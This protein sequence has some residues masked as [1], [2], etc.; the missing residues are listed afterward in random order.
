[1][2]NRVL[3]KIVTRSDVSDALA[4]QSEMLR[5]LSKLDSISL[6]Q[7][8]ELMEEVGKLC[9]DMSQA[10]RKTVTLGDTDV[11]SYNSNNTRL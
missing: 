9:L 5:R 8:G 10:I 1:M 11:A 2:V 7:M 6:M 3:P 4:L